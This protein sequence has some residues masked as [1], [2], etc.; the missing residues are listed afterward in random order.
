MESSYFEYEKNKVLQALR[1]HFISRN[2]IKIL[3]IVVN[4][5]AII[6]AMLFFFKKISPLAFL[7]SSLLWFSLMITFWFL[8]PILIYKKSKTFQ[9]RFKAILGN[10]SFTIENE[11]GAKSWDWQEFSTIMESPHFFHLYFDPRSFLIIP[12][13]AFI[14]TGIDEAGKILRT[15]INAPH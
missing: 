7:I 12:K 1:Y 11:R 15:K 8:L 10:H 9:D 5:F 13:D 4:V 3:I 2:E 14:E 6:S